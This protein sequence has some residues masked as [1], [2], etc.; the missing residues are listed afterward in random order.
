VPFTHRLV[1]LAQVALWVLVL[2]LLRRRLNAARLVVPP[3]HQPPAAEPPQRRRRSVLDDL[4]L[5][6]DEDMELP[7]S[8]RERR[9]QR[10]HA[11]VPVGER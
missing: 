10:T 4:G 3:I 2:V 7:L 9:Q 11:A 5:D 1:V 6:D 8:R